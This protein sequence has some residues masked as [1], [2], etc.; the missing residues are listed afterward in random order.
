MKSKNIEEALQALRP[1]LSEFLIENDVIENSS[2]YFSCLSPQHED[3]GPSA[4]ILPNGTKG[5]CHGCTATFD[6]LTVNHW[7]KKAPI[8]GFGFISDNL[9]PLCEHFEIPFDLGDLTEEDRFVIDSF[10]V[11]RLVSD[12]LATREWP[13]DLS[14]Y[15]EERGLSVDYCKEA[16]IGVIPD[17]DAFFAYLRKRYTL[18]FLREVGF[19]RASLFSPKNI[20]F[21]LR[22]SNGAPI[23]F[24]ARNTKWE[25]EYQAYADRG[26]IGT[27][28][29]KYNTTSGD[30]RIYRKSEFLYGFDDYLRFKKDSD[31][32]YLVEGQFD[33][34]LLAFHGV[35]N[36][37][38]LCG[39][40]LTNG[41]L[42][43]LRSKK[44]PH[45]IFALD[46]DKAGRNQIQ[47]LLVGREGSPGLLATST[48]FKISILEL[49]E[50]YEAPLQ[51]RHRGAEAAA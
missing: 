31:P 43:L 16:G 23:G 48:G 50:G 51:E 6:I 4:H 20:L 15:V 30:N 9:V 29:I 18:A 36:C 19:T 5:Y 38:S 47:N 37:V 28:P 46:G 32:L 7:L 14:S 34:D 42:G 26:K 22:D 8:S 13:E 49:P 33:R 45:L 25:E 35:H 1:R 44:I 40:A 27:P 17:Y 3:P 12:Y 24:A 21:T 41:H 10:R 11:C 2:D 39:T